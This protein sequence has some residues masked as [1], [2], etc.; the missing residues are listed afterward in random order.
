MS[1]I[2]TAFSDSIVPFFY[3]SDKYRFINYNIK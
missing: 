1:S 3:Y 2:L